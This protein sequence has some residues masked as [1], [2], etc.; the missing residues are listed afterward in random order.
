MREGGESQREFAKFLLQPLLHKSLITKKSKEKNN[1]VN[2]LRQEKLRENNK[3]YPNPVFINPGRHVCKKWFPF[4]CATKDLPIIYI[5]IMAHYVGRTSPTL[6]LLHEKEPIPSS[7]STN[8]LYTCNL[9]FSS[10]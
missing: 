3:I 4:I 6:F 5:L 2:K 7:Q 9:L 1:T 8:V 10:F